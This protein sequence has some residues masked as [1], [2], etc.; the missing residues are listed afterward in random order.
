MPGLRDVAAGMNPSS[1]PSN[2]IEV[3]GA[4]EC[5]G[6][7]DVA[8]GINPSSQ[9]SNLIEVRGALECQSLRDVGSGDKSLFPTF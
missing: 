7:R 9:P 1:Q 4:L 8:A 3:R 6:L 5:Q 2:L